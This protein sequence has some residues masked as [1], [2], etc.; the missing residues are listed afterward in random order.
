MIE[1]RQV[2]RS[3]E[4]TFLQLLCGV[5]DLDYNRASSIFF[6]EPLHDHRQNWAAFEGDEMVSILTMTP[7]EFSWGT[8]IGISGV[9]TKLG[10][11][12]NGYAGQLIEQ[13]CKSVEA[14][15]FRGFMLFAHQEDLYE[16]LGFEHVDDVIRAPLQ[17]AM[18]PEPYVLS[19]QEVHLIY[20][21]WAA[22]DPRRLIRT[23]PRWKFWEWNL[24]CCEEVGGGYICSETSLV[25]EAIV[26]EP[27]GAW[28]VLAGSEWIGMRS[29]SSELRIPIGQSKHDLYVMV[30]GMPDLPSMFMTDQF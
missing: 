29:L 1:V 14:Q 10:K 9:A 28:P 17:A 13:S 27:C 4:Q 19:N 12:G 24:R 30:K 5:F 16:S 11:R 3:E 26:P 20:N 15:G 22:A 18:T 2:G 6:S 7:L 8:S 25:R 23:E 21:R